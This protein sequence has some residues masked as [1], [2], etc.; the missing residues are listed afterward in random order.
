M[1]KVP[2]PRTPTEANESEPIRQGDDSAHKKRNSPN[3]ESSGPNR[4]PDH[5]VEPSKDDK[6]AERLR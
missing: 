1:S 6:E 3:D 4:E 5:Q 2:E